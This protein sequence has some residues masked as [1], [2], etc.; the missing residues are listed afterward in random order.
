MARPIEKPTRIAAAGNK[1][2]EIAEYIGRVNSGTTALR[3]LT[4]SHADHI[5]F[6]IQCGTPMDTRR[7]SAPG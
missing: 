3:A 2:K 5:T 6:I 4:G 7:K 1:P